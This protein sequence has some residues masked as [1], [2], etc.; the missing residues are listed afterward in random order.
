LLDSPAQTP[1]VIETLNCTVR[2]R[3][4][5]PYQ[6]F[7]L[8][9]PIS[10]SDE[11]EPQLGDVYPANSQPSAGR[12]PSCTV[13]RQTQQQKLQLLQ[14]TE[15]DEH[16]NYDEDEPSCLHYSIEWKVS[17]NNRILSKDTEQDLVLVPHAYW[18]MLLKPKL[19][20]L[21]RKK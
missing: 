18:H 14:L 10:E 1:L 15:W 19:E 11:A 12:P 17:I 21:L 16:N 2:W 9:N 3:A 5:S 13:S 7:I 8:S 4:L 6:D 20:K